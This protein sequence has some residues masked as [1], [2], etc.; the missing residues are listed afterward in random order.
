MK[1]FNQ[2]RAEPSA[3]DFVQEI[4]PVG[5]FNAEKL[6]R[7]QQR[8]QR[9]KLKIGV[10]L[11]DLMT[12]P[13]TNKLS[14]DHINDLKTWLGVKRL[15]YLLRIFMKLAGKRR[16]EKPQPKGKTFDPFEGI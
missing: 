7:K 4:K 5:N 3:Y 8:Y 1:E 16:E 15:L 2:K 14:F 6:K 13:G 10:L 11:K 12:R 9:K